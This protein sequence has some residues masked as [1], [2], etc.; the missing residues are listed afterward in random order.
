VAGNFES[1]LATGSAAATVKR[2]HSNLVLG[3]NT[4]ILPQNQQRLHELRR[5]VAE[6]PWVDYHNFSLVR[7]E[8]ID[9]AWK[10]IDPDEYRRFSLRLREEGLRSARG[11]FSGARL[12]AAQ[13]FRQREIVFRVLKEG[14]RQAPCYA[15]RLNLVLTERGDVYPC[16]ML[17]WKLGNVRE[18]GYDLRAVIAG[19]RSRDCRRAIA[20]GMEVC[21]RCTNECYLITDILFNPKELFQAWRA[22]A[23]LG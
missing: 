17:S 16:E 6:L 22:A 3:V 1:F 8:G 15:G 19:A 23:G 2:R 9:P 14:K 21:D 13:D 7:G 20:A 10:N 5:R 12:K 18:M 11:L 4:V